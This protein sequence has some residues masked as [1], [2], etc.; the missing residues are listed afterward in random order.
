MTKILLAMTVVSLAISTG[1]AMAQC[2]TAALNQ[3]A[4]RSLVGGNTV[5]GV[6]GPGY[7][8]P[9]TSPSD[10]WQEE[11]QGVNSG[12]L[13]DYKLGDGHPIDPRKQVG[14]WDT[15]GGSPARIQHAYTGGPTFLWSVHNNTAH[16]SFCQGGVEYVRAKVKPGLNVGCA[17]GDFP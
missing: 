3:S 13:L 6:P 5:C 12:P 16:Y 17:P 14:T 8:G 4:I 9:G 10:R 1:D 15:V 11:H 7:S 2:A